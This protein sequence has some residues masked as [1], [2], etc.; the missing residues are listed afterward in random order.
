M[1]APPTRYVSHG[2]AS[3]S[4]PAYCGGD[5]SY[6]WCDDGG[7]ENCSCYDACAGNCCSYNG[8]GG[9]NCGCN[10]G[11]CGGYDSCDGGCYGGCG[12]S[13]CGS[14]GECGCYDEGC[15]DGCECGP[16]CNT[17]CGPKCCF[18]ADFLYLQV[19]DA[20]VAHAQ[21]QNGIGGA[22]TV[23]FGR[24]GVAD[25]DWDSGIRLGGAIMCGPCSSFLFSYTFYESEQ[26]DTL[27]PPVIPG[28]GGAVGSLVHLPGSALTASVGPVDATYDVDF[29]TADALFRHQ[30]MGGCDYSVNFLLGAAFGQ[31]EQDFRQ[32]GTF[33]GGNAGA[34]STATS[35][36]FNGGGLKAG[37]DVNRCV[38]GPFSVY[39]KFTAAALQGKFRGHYSLLNTTTQTNLGEADWQDNR[40][41]GQFDYEA[42]LCLK[43]GRWQFSSGYMVSQWM[44]TVTTPAFIDAVQANNY[45]DV[46]DRLTFA[47]LVARVGCCW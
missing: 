34:I 46:R 27:N 38:C 39:G 35:V 31:L 43:C 36:D 14:D 1:Q 28:G 8:C 12:G 9:N 11:G 30:C 26:D 18:F 3:S 24:I 16:P 40:L 10:G 32:I 19:V 44:N 42:G 29:Q 4:Q 7:C 37:F 20:N 6:S 25:G 2:P 45:T 23:P 13:G 41:V 5:N 22:G 33:G 17:C 47:G 15:C 21:Q